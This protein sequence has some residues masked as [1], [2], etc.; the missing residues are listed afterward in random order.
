MEHH[1]AGD[2][3]NGLKW[4]RKTTLKISQELRKA[5]IDVSPKTVARLLK[6]LKFSLR[7]N[8]KKHAGNSN[9][10]RNQQF[11]YI[12]RMRRRCERGGLPIIS[13]DSKKKEM[14]G[15][16]KNPGTTWEC[17]PVAVN[18]HTFKKDA[19]GTAI[20]WGLYDTV[21]NRGHV[22]I[23]TSHETS[24]FAVTALSRWWTGTGQR[25]YS[26]AKRILIL[27][28]GGGSNGSRN[29]A[30]KHQLQTRFC[31][32]FGIKVTVCHYPPGTSKWNPIEHR[33]FSEVS[34]NWAGQ[35]LESYETILNFIRTTK[36]KTGLTVKATLLEGD[37]PIGVKTSEVQ[38]ADLHLHRHRVLPMWNYTLVPE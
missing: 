25:C 28:D 35:P 7:V 20:P 26:L 36:T 24:A 21:A 18:D 14:V 37:Y 5:D 31:N 33:L 30:W 9:P 2:P 8:H 23:G 6:G 3:I 17:E 1:T 32:R 13:I 10:F 15:R 12:Y 38:M 29:R 11:E 16:F 19:L 34:K 4:T 22:F 27:A